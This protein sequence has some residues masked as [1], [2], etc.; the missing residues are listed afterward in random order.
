MLKRAPTILPPTPNRNPI[1]NR[2]QRIGIGLGI[3]LRWMDQH[4]VSSSPTYS[5]IP[6]LQSSPTRR[7]DRFR[8]IHI[9]I[10][11]LKFRFQFH[12]KM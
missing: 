7:D 3:R 8:S 11:P 4:G 1:R 6:L 12:L 10:A 5:L 9:P 2:P